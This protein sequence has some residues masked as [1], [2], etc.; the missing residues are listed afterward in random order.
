[1]AFMWI[2]IKMIYST[3]VELRRSSLYSINVIALLQK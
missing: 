3:G 1:M 2:Y